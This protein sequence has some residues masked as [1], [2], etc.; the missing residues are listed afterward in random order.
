MLYWTKF[1]K[2]CHNM[3]IITFPTMNHDYDYNDDYDDND[4]QDQALAPWGAMANTEILSLLK[5][6]FNYQVFLITCGTCR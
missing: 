2:S 5:C 3:D 4:E 6:N 1:S